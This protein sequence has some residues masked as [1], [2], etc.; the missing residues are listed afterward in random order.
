MK[1]KAFGKKM[2]GNIQ[3]SG[4]KA[5]VDPSFEKDFQ[6]AVLTLFLNTL[7]GSHFCNLFENHFSSRP[8]EP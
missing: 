8:P 7:L 1:N 4:D 5:A 2:D 6:D 3:L